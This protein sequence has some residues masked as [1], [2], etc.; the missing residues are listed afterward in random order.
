[1]FRVLARLICTVCM[2]NLMY[3]AGEKK[4]VNNETER[5]EIF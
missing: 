2:D 5:F 4:V 3:G 1:M